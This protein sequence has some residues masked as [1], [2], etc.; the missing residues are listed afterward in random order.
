LLPSLRQTALRETER[1]GPLSKVLVAGLSDTLSEQARS[2]GD[3]EE[4][5]DAL[6]ES[7]RAMWPGIHLS[8]KEFLSHLAKRLAGEPQLEQALH[9]TRGPD[10]YLACASAKGNSRAIT[11]LERDFLRDI[12]SAVARLRLSKSTVDE[13]QQLVREKLLLGRGDAEPKIADYAGRGP[14]DNWVRVVAMRTALSFMRSRSGEPYMDDALADRAVAN[15]PAGSGD[16]ELDIVRARYEG[17][18]KAALEGVLS[19]LPAQDRTVL[20]LHYVDGLNIDQI[21]GI[22]R[23]HRST[24]ARWIA[25]TRERLLADAKQV[26]MTQLKLTTKEF[27]SLMTAMQSQLHL[28]IHRFLGREE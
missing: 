20:R 26:L 7:S 22:Y 27:Q 13:I 11:I 2:I 21:G 14:L 8:Q 19:R 10:L 25:K 1:L 4:L 12:P 18:F 5:L 16:P 15:M 28:S 24:V 9:A 6:Y 23:V 17:D 3:L